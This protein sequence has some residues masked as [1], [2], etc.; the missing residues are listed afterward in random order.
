MQRAS[1]W[2][3]KTLET[4]KLHSLEKRRIRNDFVLTHNIL[5]NENGFWIIIT[6]H[7]VIILVADSEVS[8]ILDRDF[9]VMSGLVVHYPNH[10]WSTVFLLENI[11]CVSALLSLT[12]SGSFGTCVL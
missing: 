2:W 3:R 7:G 9:Q 4:L 1:K 11:G 5:Y 10:S 6:L 12:H 8:L